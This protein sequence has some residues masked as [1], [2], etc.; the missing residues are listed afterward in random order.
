MATK[1]HY[2]LLFLSSVTERKKIQ[3]LNN[4]CKFFNDSRLGL[5]GISGLTMASYL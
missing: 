5:E 1:L 4:R 3:I 2:K